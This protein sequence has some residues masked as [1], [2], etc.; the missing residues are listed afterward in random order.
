MPHQDSLTV[1]APVRSGAQAALDEALKAAGATP[2]SDAAIPFEQLTGVHFARLIALPAGQAADGS[3]MSAKVVW[4]SDVDAPLKRHVTE[5]A[6]RA[7]PAL[8]L[9]LQHCEGYP[10]SPDTGQRLAYLR[11]HTVKAAAVYVNT[12]G[13]GVE[14]VVLERRLHDAIESFLDAHA[15]ELALRDPHE[16]RAA[17]QRF[18]AADETLRPALEPAPQLELAFR[19]RET[20]HAV[21]V[22]VAILAFTPLIVPLLP[23]YAIALRLHEVRDVPDRAVPDDAHVEVLAALEDLFEQN[24]FT[25]SGP[26]KPG[27]FRRYTAMAVLWLASYAVRHVFNDANLAGVKTIHFAR[28]VFLDNGRRVVF[29]SNY[30]GSVESYMD[31]FIDKVAW[32][33]NGV[34]SN[35]LGYPE[36]AGS[37]AVARATS[38]RSRTSFADTSRRHRSGTR[39]IRT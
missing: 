38:R 22:P 20:A 26:L 23:L 15:T 36:R 30:D 19:I 27:P 39:P 9:V 29:A 10:E 32:G 25:A 3:P 11:A 12:V 1:V 6:D 31:D 14:Q 8:D 34:F 33:L 35:G 24:P 2:P 37:C 17:I 4:I 7:G 13:R 21:L 28:W 5:L 16:V 18:V